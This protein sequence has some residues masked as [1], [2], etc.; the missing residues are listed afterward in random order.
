ME[1]ESP[2]SVGLH[3]W[4]FS[5]HLRILGS[6]NPRYKWLFL[7]LLPFLFDPLLK[8]RYHWER[9]DLGPR[10]EICGVEACCG[11]KIKQMI[12][13]EVSLVSHGLGLE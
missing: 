10:F 6:P 12:K 3:R 5:L 8:L 2:P 7:S 1:V 9:E 11:G 4:R 13:I